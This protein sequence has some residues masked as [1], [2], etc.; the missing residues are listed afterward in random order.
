[1]DHSYKLGLQDIYPT[2][3]LDKDGCGPNQA[4]C[5]SQTSNP[6]IYD[7]SHEGFRKDR[8]VR[9]AKINKTLFAIFMKMLEWL[10]KIDQ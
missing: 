2:I 10:G 6:L 7:P 9:T 8:A 4:H 5:R 3:A 1:M